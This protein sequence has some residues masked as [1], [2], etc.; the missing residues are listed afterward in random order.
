MQALKLETTLKT[1]GTTAQSLYKVAEAK[2]VGSEQRVIKILADTH[3][4]ECGHKSGVMTSHFHSVCLGDGESDG[5]ERCNVGR[6]NR[7]DNMASSMSD[8]PF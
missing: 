1:T 7:V 8:L 3:V 6:I 4:A 5:H 2:L